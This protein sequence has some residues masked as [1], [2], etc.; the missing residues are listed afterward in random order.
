LERIKSQHAKRIFFPRILTAAKVDKQTRIMNG[1]VVT[2]LWRRLR[3]ATP[4]LAEHKR[5]GFFQKVCGVSQASVSRW[6]T[7]ENEPS[8]ANAK[9]I[10]RA[11]GF[12]VQWVL[13]GDGPERWQHD[14]RD[15]D[16]MIAA[17]DALPPEDRE[18]ILRYAEFRAAGK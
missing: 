3:A 1:R 16:K 2:D 7:G 11:T 10:S 12:C 8:L 13:E 9:A 14:Q 4:D 5:S 15:V 17:L 18:D 6:K